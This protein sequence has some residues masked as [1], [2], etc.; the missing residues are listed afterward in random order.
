[1]SVLIYDHAEAMNYE[2]AHSLSLMLLIFA[3]ATLFVVYSLTRRFQVV[4]L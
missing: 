2:A 1:L 3:F 4:R